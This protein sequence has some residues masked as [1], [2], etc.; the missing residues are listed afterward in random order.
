MSIRFSVLIPVYNRAREVAET[1]D[2]LLSQVTA[3]DE[4]FVID[5]GSTDRTWQVLESYG[6]RIKPLRQPNQGPEVARKR[7]A[8]VAQGEYLV[9]LDSDDLLLPGALAIYDRVIRAFDF[10]PLIIGAMTYF[11]DGEPLPAATAM[12]DTVEVLKYQDYLSKDIPVHMSNSRIVIR[13]TAFDRAGGLRESSAATFLTDDFDLVLRAGTCGPCIFVR[14]PNTVAYRKHASGAHRNVSAMKD[15]ILRMA[16]T[17]RQGLY[18]GGNERCAARYAYIGGM[19]ASFAYRHCW[20]KGFR[21]PALKLLAGTAP[22][23]AVAVGNRFLRWFRKR[24]AP[25]VLP[26]SPT[27]VNTTSANS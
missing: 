22:M 6:T 5:D 19:A 7:A 15:G 18:P 13:R 4:I 25:T 3:E 27:P 14:Q 1:I 8:A 12:P 26:F 9:F 20:R 21:G 24:T 23:V 11:R 16:R 17:E 10:P 2:S